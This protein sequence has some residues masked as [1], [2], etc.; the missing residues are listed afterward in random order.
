MI[1]PRDIREKDY[2]K[3]A[4]LLIRK[5]K[6]ISSE[7]FDSLEEFWMKSWNQLFARIK[8]KLM[9]FWFLSMKKRRRL[10][11][12]EAFSFNRFGLFRQLRMLSMPS[13]FQWWESAPNSLISL[14]INVTDLIWTKVLN[15][16]WNSRREGIR[17]LRQEIQKQTSSSDH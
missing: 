15:F 4:I 8:R 3:P 14:Y 7:T 11:S 1:T 9:T 12:L 2:Q 17:R 5:I 16:I 13:R 10:N 6:C